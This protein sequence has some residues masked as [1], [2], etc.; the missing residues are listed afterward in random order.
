M[1]KKKVFRYFG[2]N[3]LITSEIELININPM[4]MIRLEAAAN[5]ILTNGEKTAYCIDVF[6]EDVDTWQEIEIVITE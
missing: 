2:K 6:P 5:H 3:G 4:Q 1:T